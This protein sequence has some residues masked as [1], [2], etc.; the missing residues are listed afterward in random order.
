MT[1]TPATFERFQL[2][3]AEL[4]ARFERYR[5]EYR[6]GGYDEASLRN[7][8]LNA[9]FRALGWDV[10]NELGHPPHLR[11]VRVEYAATD[12]QSNRRADYVF[13]ING[14]DR[15]VCE[16]KKYPEKMEHYHYQAQNYAFNLRLWVAVLFNFDELSLFVVGGK[17][18]KEKPF[19]PAPGW[20]L[21]SWQYETVARQIW[22]LLSRESVENGSL[23][24]FVQSLPKVSSSKS[25]QL[26]LIKPDRSKAVDA[27][28]LSYL[29]TQR[30]RLARHLLHDNRH[31]K[32][33]VPA[34]NE[35]VQRTI[36]RLLFQRVCEDRDIDTFQ[37]LQGALS[38][39]VNEGRTKGRL[40]SIIVANYPNLTAAF[41]GGLYGRAG[42][43]RHFTES[44]HVDDAWLENF[45]E[46]LAGEDL[47]YLF[48]QIPIEILGSVYERFLGSIVDEKGRVHQKPEIRR[49]GGV[50]YTPG[51]IVRYIVNAAL[52]PLVREKSPEQIRKIRI[53]DP[54]CGSGT[55][56][57]A[58]LEKLSQACVEYYLANPRS[59]N[60]RN[61]YIDF[62]GDLKLTNEL[63]RQ[64]AVDCIF[65]VDIDPQ[66]IEVAEMSLYLKILE[67]ESQS[68]L[69]KQKLLFPDETFLPDLSRNLIVG[70]S[71]VST[72]ARALLPDQDV[73]TA[74]PMSWEET[75][76]ALADQKFDVVIGNPP[77]DVIEK[78]RGSASWPHDIFRAYLD[79][80]E[81][82]DA[83][84]G[85]KLNLFR[86]FLIQAL[87]LCR[88]AGRVGM[89]VPMSILADISCSGTRFAILD[90][91][92]EMTVDA[93]P[94]K[95]NKNR[96]VF[97]EA[98]LSTVIL[99]CVKRGA[100][101]ARDLDIDLRVYP[102]SS[103]EE[104]AKRAT[105]KRSEL[106][107]LDPE[108]LPIP[109][110]DDAAW[111]LAVKLHR[112]NHVTRLKNAPGIAITRGEINQTVYRK[113]ITKNG[114]DAR[115]L[116]GVEVAPFQI[117]A[118]L[119]QGELEYL[120]LKKFKRDHSVPPQTLAG[121]IATQRITGVDERLRVRCNVR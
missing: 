58:A 53:I 98:K 117:R 47:A 82:L 120:N 110:C 90:A 17:P 6:K 3:A 34:I 39:W 101:K 19:S 32:W 43:P 76:P 84:K 59:Q 7:D 29:E 16:A 31:L 116:K 109:L 56:L 52:D 9:F 11:E 81:R 1:F 83:A 38:Q 100:R 106:S 23:E 50:F 95:D 54:A 26:W 57:I 97:Y 62:N 18:N 66:A 75:F 88:P 55:F 104:A 12:G 71:L 105:I 30:G 87:E 115:M 78:E 40:W 22:D 119:S 2:K 27:D 15:F 103:F 102:G 20:R 51:H 121:R 113:Y 91:V 86:F 79:H 107:V 64:L 61:C 48:A 67:G 46:E 114:S 35:A 42:Q 72:D 63:K 77:Y 74:R 96:R 28:F 8:Y 93:F 21:W 65:G 14:M 25:R 73:E 41:N 49:Q 92:S 36:D 118:K 44:C 111:N 60:P 5:E 70:N 80:T 108:T 24:R 99:S 89:I 10:D 85:G 13:R 33:D 94:Q 112:S 45:I 37:T 69:R 4:S 68:S